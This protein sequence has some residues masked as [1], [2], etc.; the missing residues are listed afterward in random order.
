MW[1]QQNTSKNLKLR[2]KQGMCRFAIRN[3]K[4]SLII[5]DP[6]QITAPI[7]VVAHIAVPSRPSGAELEN[8]NVNLDPPK[9]S[10]FS[11]KRSVFG[12][13]VALISHPWRIQEDLENILSWF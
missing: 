4:E 7:W 13:Y 9:V 2:T 11:P 1:N 5:L 3:P 8:R 6:L 12:G 10:N